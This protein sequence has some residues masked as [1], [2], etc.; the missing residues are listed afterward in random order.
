MRN[1]NFSERCIREDLWRQLCALTVNQLS[2]ASIQPD[3][4]ITGLG[5]CW[6]WEHFWKGHAVQKKETQSPRGKASCSN[7]HFM[8]CV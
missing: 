2:Q 4:G 5:R 1:A 8:P 3:L 7:L 6:L